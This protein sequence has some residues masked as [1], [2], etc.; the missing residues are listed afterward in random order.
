[1]SNSFYATKRLRGE[2]TVP[3]DKSI[4]HRG[5]MFGAI[6]SGTTEL[7]GFLP[8][9]DCVSTINCFRKMGIDIKHDGDHVV[10]HGRGLHGLS[11]PEGTLDAG[12]SGTTT[13]LISGILAGQ[14]FSTVIDGDDSLR[15]RPMKRIM[16]PL[17][18]MGADI[19][20][21]ASLRMTGEAG[22]AG[23][24]I[25]RD[26]DNTIEG[27]LPLI[28]SP[29]AGG[30]HGISY[31]SPVASAQ[32]KSCILLAGMY[33]DSPTTVFEPALS[34]DHTERMLR[35]FGA[36]VESNLRFSATIQPEPKLS[37]QRIEIPGDISS[38]A[39]FIAAGLIHPD[40]EILI[41]NVGVNPTRA[42]IIKVAAEMGGNIQLENR[43]TVSG[44][45]VADILVRS[46][47]LHGIEI[48][49]AAIPTLIDEIP[50]IAVMAACAT[51][52]TIIR[53]AAELKVKE[54]DRIAT[55]AENLSAMGADITPTEDGM[56]IR[57]LSNKKGSA[58]LFGAP[59]KTYLDHRIAMSFAVA[60]L[61]AEGT[62]T[63]DHPECVDISYPE[64]Y[65]T[66][67]A[68]SE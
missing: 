20:S 14:S 26:P 4:S 46:S 50:M 42:G 63:M 3:G 35:G 51:G 48:G 38:A 57:G 43:R 68:I 59:I 28:I 40:A 10:L 11:A 32:V 62:T 8:G 64:F 47:S 6:A 27:C 56:I 30:L 39:Y 65:A 15:S 34:R 2:V 53:D 37:G 52:E 25:V 22:M 18:Q 16:E 60:S 58:P 12:N 55:V 17:G 1:M 5:V 13:R 54:S 19:G 33:A 21:F 66:L 67:A 49:G 24:S 61:V 7:F 31:T 29:A 23:G 36:D 9:A 41:K 44:E 45:D